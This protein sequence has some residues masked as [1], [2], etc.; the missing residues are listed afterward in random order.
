MG[1][2]QPA[3]EG[4]DGIRYP[5]AMIRRWP[6]APLIDAT[7]ALLLA[8]ALLA[9]VWTFPAPVPQRGLTVAALFVTLP[10]ALRCRYP[11]A[12]AVLV[13]GGIVALQTISSDFSNNAAFN[14]A[15][16][17]L[18]LYSVGA[19][20]RGKR[21][22]V[23]GVTVFAIVVVLFVTEGDSPMT[24][25]WFAF[26]AL[27]LGGPWLIGVVMRLRRD[28]ERVAI[29]RAVEL[30][31]RQDEY[32]RDAVQAERNRI[33]RELH[34]VVAHAISVTVLQARGGQRI[35]ETHPE[36]AREAFGAILATGEQALGEMRRLLGMLREDGERGTLAPQPSIQH[37][38]ALVEQVRSAGLE[39]ELQVEGEPRPLPPGVDIS[40]YRIVQ[41]ALINVVRHAGPAVARVLVDYRPEA[42]EVSVVDNGH[43]GP[44]PTPG[45]HG[46]IGISE[47][48]A[49]IGGTLA[50]G[51][52]PA[53]GFAVRAL[54]PTVVEQ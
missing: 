52:N 12:V 49:L 2:R 33:A 30:E 44:D 10:L 39:V 42:V 28:S 54:L 8:G 51:P 43:G 13:A 26:A 17:M 50:V 31:L 46:I 5:L 27:F 40:A 45:G 7:I 16:F 11:I 34:D 38:T 4:R 48:V 23:G 22:V 21:S 37:L 20:T 32:A 15:S 24:P 41:E 47:R 6:L 9:E 18:A 36:R 29:A 35:V 14:D 25:V 19:N 3:D 53:G 1:L